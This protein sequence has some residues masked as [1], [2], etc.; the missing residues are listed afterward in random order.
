MARKNTRLI[1][2][3]QF[4]N[5]AIIILRLTLSP[6]FASS[7]SALATVATNIST[8]CFAPRQQGSEDTT[9]DCDSAVDLPPPL[10]FQ[11]IKKPGGP[12]DQV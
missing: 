10:L 8:V 7:D 2:V 9:L 12:V 1:C 4:L 11:D 6:T 5:P 3:L